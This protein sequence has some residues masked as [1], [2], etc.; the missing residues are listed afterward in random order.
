M[1]LLLSSVPSVPHVKIS[2]YQGSSV[3]GSESNPF[4]GC[5]FIALVRDRSDRL[6]ETHKPHQS[7]ATQLAFRNCYQPRKVWPEES[8][9]QFRTE[10]AS[11]AD[12]STQ[13]MRAG[14]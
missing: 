10:M 4:V 8:W 1:I 3:V 14:R 9:Q 6:C 2:V 13:L 11:N 7:Q 12:N 5:L